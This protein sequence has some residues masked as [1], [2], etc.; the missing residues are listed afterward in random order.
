[1]VWSPRSAVAMEPKPRWASWAPHPALASHVSTY[2]TIR[3]ERTSTIKVLPDACADVTFELSQGGAPRAHVAPA[4]ARPV[5]YPM[6][7]GT[8]LFGARLFPQSAALLIGAPLSSL[9][10]GWN[11]LEKFV[12]AAATELAMRLAAAE[13]DTDR[14][15][16]LDAFFVQ[17]LLARAVDDR[18]SK[19]LEAIFASGGMISMARV[20]KAGA[21]S[22]RTL[23]RLFDRWVGLSPKRFA[24]IVRFQRALRRLDG[25]P[26][27][28]ALAIE[29]GYFD[30]AHLIRE[31]RAL[32]GAAPTEA[33][34]LEAF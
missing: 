15:L 29:L 27:W 14:T 28:A 33:S 12:G 4:Q 5:T 7:E 31:M 26:D 2:W 1:M 17:A 20:A 8:W 32:F 22:E 3:A 30:Q 6:T 24:R 9:A 10:E 11:P 13:E 19:S 16:L 18:V 25:A 23:G 34:R 21:V